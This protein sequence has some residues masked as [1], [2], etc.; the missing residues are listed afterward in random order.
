MK[1]LFCSFN[2]GMLNFGGLSDTTLAVLEDPVAS[3]RS[4]PG[5]MPSLK[6]TLFLSD[7]FVP[8]FGKIHK[9]DFSLFKT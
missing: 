7:D 4:V 9:S 8:R 1:L 3:S 6:M 2:C 5:R